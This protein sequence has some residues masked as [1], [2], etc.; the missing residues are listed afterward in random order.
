MKE[1]KV[2]PVV[3][4][5]TAALLS[6]TPVL[7]VP[8]PSSVPP[9]VRLDAPALVVQ[10]DA[11]ASST[12]NLKRLKKKALLAKHDLLSEVNRVEQVSKPAPAPGPL[13]THESPEFIE[14]ASSVASPL[15]VTS[16]TGESRE[17]DFAALS[18][19][20]VKAKRPSELDRRKGRPQ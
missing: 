6:A 7:A 4:V 8:V 10:P 15:P 14:A 1:R 16:P 20:A 12:A 5:A 18:N 2:S 11:A 9:T 17:P 13:A 3:T 19:T